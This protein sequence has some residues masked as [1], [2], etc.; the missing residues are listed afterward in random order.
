MKKPKWGTELGRLLW[1][2]GKCD[3]EIADEFGIAISAVTSYRKRHWERGVQMSA[4][5]APDLQNENWTPATVDVPEE[6]EEEP[7][8]EDNSLEIPCEAALVPKQE[9][10]SVQFE[11]V[12]N[13]YEILEAAT[14][15]LN[16]IQAICTADAILCLWNWN[17]PEDLKRARAA[18]DHLLKKLEV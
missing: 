17:G 5:Q 1:L 7:V 8:Y 14:S 6:Q 16:G 2:E 4:H 10:A 18:I 15:N 11:N 13:V 12:T 3:G 9:P